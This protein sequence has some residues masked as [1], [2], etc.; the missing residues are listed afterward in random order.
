VS[1]LC[2]IFDKTGTIQPA[3]IAKAQ[4]LSASQLTGEKVIFAAEMPA[5]GD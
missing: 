2:Y 4:E 3:P 5:W 1:G